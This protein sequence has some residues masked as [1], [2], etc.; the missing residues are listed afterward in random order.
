MLRFA[1]S[2]ARSS[3]RCWRPCERLEK[4][5]G[6]TVSVEHSGLLPTT[7]RRLQGQQR[8]HNLRTRR[9]LRRGL[10][11]QIVFYIIDHLSAGWRPV[12]LRYRKGNPAA[13]RQPRK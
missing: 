9:W 13:R 10:L 1:G 7:P 11:T 8:G 5:D 12:T 6:R 2:A 4:G 3:K